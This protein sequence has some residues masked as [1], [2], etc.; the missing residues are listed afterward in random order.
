MSNFP[1]SFPL[2]PAQ[3]LSLFPDLFNPTIDA[4][5]SLFYGTAEPLKT[6]PSQLRGNANTGELQ[7]RKSDN[8]GWR[9]LAKLDKDWGGLVPLAGGVVMEGQI[10]MGGFGIVNLPLGSGNAPARYADLAPYAKLDGSVAF[11]GIPTLPGIDP[12]IGNHATR[13]SYVDTVAKAGGTF[14]AIISVPFAPTAADH[15]T[16]KSYVDG[17]IQTHGHTGGAAGV[18][19]EAATA[20]KATGI[21]AGRGLTADGA[22]GVTWG[23]PLL[24]IYPKPKV[25]ARHPFN[26][27]NFPTVALGWSTNVDLSPYVAVGAKFVLLLVRLYA[28][29]GSFTGNVAFRPSGTATIFDDAIKVLVDTGGSGPVPALEAFSVPSLNSASTFLAWVEV[30]STRKFDWLTDLTGNNNVYGAAFWLIGES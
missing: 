7:I 19:L 16:R 9:P 17:E 26:S 6:Y 30:D 18:K 21:L 13:K 28:S 4:L 10:D 12:S 27:G 8:S 25:V 2:S 3:L 5:A 29:S 1:T 23:A 24:K 15:V 14:A 20:L 22:N 11:T